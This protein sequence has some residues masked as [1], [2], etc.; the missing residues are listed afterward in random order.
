MRAWI[1][2]SFLS[3]YLLAHTE[4][5]QLIKLPVLFSHYQD[6]Q[7]SHTISFLEFLSLHYASHHSG[8]DQQHEN[9]PFQ[10]NE[11]H[12]IQFTLMAIPEEVFEV[13]VS[14]ASIT[15]PVTS[16]YQRFIPTSGNKSIWQPPRI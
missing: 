4:V 12:I 14:N 6:H 15:Q 9:L 8:E 13:K 11:F 5:H 7:Q 10:D 2:I 16:H 1:A 3:I